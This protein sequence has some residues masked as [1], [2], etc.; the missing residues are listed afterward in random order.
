MT[1]KGHKHSEESKN[2]MMGRLPWNKGL[3]GVHLSPETEFKKGH[4]SPETAFKKG[5]TPLNKG[6][7]IQTNTE[8]PD[9][10]GNTFALIHGKSREPYSQDWNKKLKQTIM[11]RD[12]FI[13]I[14]CGQK[15]D[16]PHH[17][18]Y[19]KKNSNPDNLIT[20]CNSCHSNTN[21]NRKQWES[22]FYMALELAQRYK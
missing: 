8:R 6:L 5:Q 4:P 13:C 7:H 15:G 22:Y 20:L 12:D 11:E 10:I 2:K 3:K 19:N 9:M 16:I 1:F 21:F 17:I 18:D 14:C